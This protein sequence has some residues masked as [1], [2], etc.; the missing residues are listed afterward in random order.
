VLSVVLGDFP[1]GT[2]EELK[3]NAVD[4]V[5]SMGLSGRIEPGGQGTDPTTA[6]VCPLAR[7]VH[8]HRQAVEESVVESVGENLLPVPVVVGIDQRIDDLR[9]RDPAQRK[10]LVKGD[11]RNVLQPWMP[12]RLEGIQ[13]STR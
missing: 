13:V 10:P 7:D 9:P 3:D 1:A 8:E 5:A 2:P 12:R 11:A 6:L 4:D